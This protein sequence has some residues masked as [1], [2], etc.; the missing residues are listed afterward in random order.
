MPTDW[1]VENRTLVFPWL[2]DS[3]LSL[4]Q[5]HQ[6]FPKPAIKEILQRTSEA[7]K[8][9]HDKDWIH[10]GTA[11][12]ISNT[13]LQELALIVAPRSETRQHHGRLV[14]QRARHPYD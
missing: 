6:D 4:L 5:N 12:C 3:L 8:G 7:V 13:L 2:R 14:S 9:F 1:D 11:L 10:I